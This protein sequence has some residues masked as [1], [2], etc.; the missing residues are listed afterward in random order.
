MRLRLAMNKSAGILVDPLRYM[1]IIERRFAEI[2][3]KPNPA[4]KMD[5]PIAVAIMPDVLLS[6]TDFNPLQLCKTTR[7]LSMLELEMDK[8]I[9]LK[10]R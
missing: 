10:K 3:N 7:R 4:F 2:A 5:V 8:F 6:T 9:P 1:T